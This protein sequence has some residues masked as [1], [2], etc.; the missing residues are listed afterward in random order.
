[1]VRVVSTARTSF[2]DQSCETA[3]EGNAGDAAASV[4]VVVALSS[5]LATPPSAAA[6]TRRNLGLTGVSAT[7]VNTDAQSR[8]TT[9]ALTDC[10][11]AGFQAGPE[12]TCQ[13]LLRKRR[14]AQDHQATEG[15]KTEG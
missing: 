1:M 13:H 3:A 12:F 11:Q 5:A 6:T 10:R 15:S 4:S 9:F 7:L 14:H 2:V 8:G